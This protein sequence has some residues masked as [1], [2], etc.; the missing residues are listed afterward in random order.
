ML[1]EPQALE[2][3]P[4]ERLN[5][6]RIRAFR[7]HLAETNTPRSVAVV[8][9]TLYHAARLMM[10]EQDWAWLK[11]IKARLYRHA[12]SGRATGSPI[13][14][15][16]LWDFGEQLMEGSKPSPDTLIRMRD[17]VRTAMG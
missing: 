5:A 13:T 9:D 15:V 10:S 3:A 7:T 14:S 16:Q 1:H 8:V 6:D 2:F 17:A 4:A 11:A 12:P